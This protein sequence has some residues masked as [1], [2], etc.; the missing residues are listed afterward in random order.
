MACHSVTHLVCLAQHFLARD[1]SSAP[2]VLPKSGSCPA[3]HHPAEWDEIIRAAYARRDYTK[4]E[5]VRR[6]KEDKKAAERLEREEAKAEKKRAALEERAHK[7]AAKARATQQVEVDSGDEDA[8]T[9]ETS[10]RNY[11]LT[12]DQ[13]SDESLSDVEMRLVQGVKGGTA[14]KPPESPSDLSFEQMTL[15]TPPKRRKGAATKTPP[16]SQYIEVDSDGDVH[17]E[18]LV[19]TPTKRRKTRPSAALSLDSE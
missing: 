5:L 9:R 6:A 2:A 3:C 15:V 4:D 17:T 13:S 11:G 19:L 14:T 12:K 7:R 18:H 8:E 10:N 1:R 16:A